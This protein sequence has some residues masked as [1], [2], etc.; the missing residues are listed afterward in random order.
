MTNKQI[1]AALQLVDDMRRIKKET[2]PGA[3]TVVHS[4]MWMIVAACERLAGLE[5]R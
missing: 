1:K 2:R 4:P 3:G 5:Q